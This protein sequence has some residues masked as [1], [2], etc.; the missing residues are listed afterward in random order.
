M[1]IA[2]RIGVMNHGRLEQLG[3]AEDLY[4]R[5]ASRFVATFIGKC[6]VIE[7][8]TVGPGRF[9]ARDGRQLAFGGGQGGA[10]LCFRPERA[11]LVESDVDDA[12]SLDV[13]VRSATYLGPVIEHE[14]VTS[15]G[16]RL[17]VATPAA[18]RTA[19]VE[20]GRPLK[21]S[22]RVEDCFAVA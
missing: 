9:E 20:P 19:R 10:A 14:V 5:P 4:L 13:T 12:N 15:A 22:W 18:A 2:D 11:R 1:A 21:L 16:D 3:T 7:G 8:R 6:N 17:L